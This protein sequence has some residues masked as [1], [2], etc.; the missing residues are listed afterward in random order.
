MEQRFVGLLQDGGTALEPFFHGYQEL[1]SFNMVGILA[2]G[3]GEQV[4]RRLKLILTKIDQRHEEQAGGV[5]GVMRQADF[6]NLPCPGQIT[7]LKIDIRQQG[8]GQGI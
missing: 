3:P 4:L 1:G 6:A 8:V 5:M 2:Q 7:F